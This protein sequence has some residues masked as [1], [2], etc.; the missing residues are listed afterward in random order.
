MTTATIVDRKGHVIQN[1]HFVDWLFKSPTA[2]WLWLLPR[3]WLGWQWIEAALHKI[4]KPEWVQTGDAVKGFW[5]GAVQVPEVGRPT[6]AFDW[7]RSFLQSM[8]DAEAYRWMAPL[9]AWGEMLVGIALILG[10][11]TGIA[12]FFG[13]LM[14]WN[15][16]MAGTAS[17]NPMLFLIAVGLIMAWKV[18]GYI[19]ADY[20]LLRWIG[21]PWRWRGEV[22]DDRG[23]RE[24]DR[25]VVD[26]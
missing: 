7:Y 12:A 3:L 21:V 13:A 1:P 11:F 14:N 23:V 9:V 4:D 20:F 25:V 6:V 26:G 15:F 16:M 5:T 22:V 18:A 8:L 17:S 19:G 24:V 10:A 2:G